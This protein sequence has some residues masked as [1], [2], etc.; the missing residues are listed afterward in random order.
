MLFHLCCELNVYLYLLTIL[1]NLKFQ[2]KKAPYIS[3]MCVYNMHYETRVTIFKSK[4]NKHDSKHLF[5]PESLTLYR[6][7]FAHVTSLHL[8]HNPDRSTITILT[9]QTR[10]SRHG[11]V[12]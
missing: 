1:N 5:Y 12:K 10:E 8:H 2:R 7:Q 9:V 6:E 11:V 4:N 3:W